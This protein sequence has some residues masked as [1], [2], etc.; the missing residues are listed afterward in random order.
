MRKGLRTTFYYRFLLINKTINARVL[1]N[2]SPSDYWY[3]FNT[4]I[5]SYFSICILWNHHCLSGFN[6]RGF[7][8]VPLPT[9]LPYIP[10]TNKLMNCLAL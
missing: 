2:M 4:T 6:V 7:R 1:P 5:V 8:G 9:N 10:T 3:A